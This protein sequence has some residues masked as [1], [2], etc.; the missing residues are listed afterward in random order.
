MKPY[1]PEK[2]KQ[3]IF[4]NDGNRAPRPDGFDNFYFKDTWRIAGDEVIAAV[5]DFFEHGKMLEALK[6]TLIT[7]IPENACH[8]NVSD[9]RPISCCN[10]LYKCITKM[11]YNRLRL[12]LPSQVKETQGAIVHSRQI[13]HNIMIVQDLVK[14]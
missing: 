14:H 11:I 5:V 13:V 1:S 8:K 4:S 6:T 2:V 7:R 3:V 12:V 9:F 10:T